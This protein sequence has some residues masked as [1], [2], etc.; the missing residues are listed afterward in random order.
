M[1]EILYL[2]FVGVVVHD[3]KRIILHRKYAFYVCFTRFSGASCG[4]INIPFVCRYDFQAKLIFP[5][6]AHVGIH[7][8]WYLHYRRDPLL[9]IIILCTN[10][11]C[12]VSVSLLY[13]SNSFFKINRT[14]C[15]GRCS[16]RHR[17]EIPLSS[18]PRDDL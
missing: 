9:Y 12:A 16:D 10:D 15:G 13:F 3:N 17:R 8:T 6:E 11:V 1:C 7:I 14:F 2:Y 18:W 4:S 5:L